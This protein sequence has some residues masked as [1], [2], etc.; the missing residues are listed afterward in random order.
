MGQVEPWRFAKKDRKS[1]RW[2]I[3][4]GGNLVSNDEIESLNINL[5]LW[6]PIHKGYCTLNELRTVYDI[7]DL[8]DMH[9]AISVFNTLEQR[10]YKK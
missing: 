2:I 10:A 5:F 8:L 6:A 9:E 1:P 4:K 3:Q 7:E